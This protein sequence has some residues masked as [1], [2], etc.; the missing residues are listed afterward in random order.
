MH[1]PTTHNEHAPLT[2]PAC[3]SW[4]E[5][6]AGHDYDMVTNSTGHL[7][8]YHE[9]R[10]AA[11][12][13][14][15]QLLPGD[16]HDITVGLFAEE[17]AAGGVAEC[18]PALLFLGAENPLLTSEDARAAAHALLEAAHSLDSLD[19]DWQAVRAAAHEIDPSPLTCPPWCVAP[20][21]QP[22]YIAGGASAEHWIW[23]GARDGIEVSVDV[24]DGDNGLD[25]PN[26]TVSGR[27]EQLT[28]DQADTLVALVTTAAARL[29]EFGKLEASPS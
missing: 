24:F 23:Q 6:P 9:K 25:E 26:I 13:L 17:T 5:Q 28:A 15:A 4:C 20:H 18:G 11:V 16:G 10:L 19:P 7:S 8:R 27:V 22:R 21:D 2:I 29:R 3:P 14:A 12:D 1:N